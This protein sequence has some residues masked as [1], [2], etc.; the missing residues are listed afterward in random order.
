MPSNSDF[1]DEQ[2]LKTYAKKRR[3]RKRADAWL[4]KP[5]TLRRLEG[6]ARERLEVKRYQGLLDAL[7][8]SYIVHSTQLLRFQDVTRRLPNKETLREKLE[9]IGFGN[10]GKTLLAEFNR[11][12]ERKRINGDEVLKLLWELARLWNAGPGPKD[13]VESQ[14]AAIGSAIGATRVL[15]EKRK[16]NPSRV[17][18]DFDKWGFWRLPV[19]LDAYTKYVE[20][21]IAEESNLSKKSEYERAVVSLLPYQLKSKSIPLELFTAILERYDLHIKPGALK[22]KFQ[23]RTPRKK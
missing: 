3:G 10:K 20:K 12:I 2:F 6:Q 23:R 13:A 15:L 4:E 19:M 9:G 11:W 16:F 17:F 22:K 7:D 18:D 1:S 21:V 14:L 8:V 5:D